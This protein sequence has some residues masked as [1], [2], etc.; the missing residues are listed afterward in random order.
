MKALLLSIGV[1]TGI[2]VF[3]GLVLGSV[4]LAYE[5]GGFVACEVLTTDF[6]A[7]GFMFGLSAMVHCFLYR[8]RSRG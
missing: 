7:L 5:A 1:A 6:A 4:W 2:M 3:L 8:G